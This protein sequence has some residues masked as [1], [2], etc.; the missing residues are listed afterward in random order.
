MSG[1]IKLAALQTELVVK[2]DKFQSELKK[3]SDMGVSEADK[4]SDKMS[5]AVD[6]GIDKMSALGDG[7]TLGLT[8]PILAAGTA[9][10]KFASDTNDQMAVLQ[11]QLGTT[12]EETETLREVALAVYEN[13]F[14]DSLE[15]CIAD[16]GTMRMNLRES[17][18]WTEE[19]TQRTLE[20]IETITSLFD[21]NA[22]EVTRTVQVMQSS[23]LIDNVQE[24]LDIITAGFQNGANYS[25]EL[26][27][28]LREYSPQFVKLGLSADEAMAY[29][30]QGAENGAF[31]LDKVGDAMKEFSIRVVDGS[32]TTKAGFDAINMS[33]DEM[34]EKFGAGGETAK[35]AFKDTLEGLASIEDP[36][37]RNTAGVNLFGTMWED[38]GETVI[39]S[40]A[41][42]EGGLENVEGATERA[43]EQINNTFSS[44]LKSDLRE[45]GDAFLPL[46][47][48][49]LDLAE[50]AMPLLEDAVEEI[51]GVLEDMDTETA[52]NVIQTM[53]M[54]AAIGPAIKT[55]SGGIS[56]FKTFT[57]AISGAAQAV[58]IASGA[59]LT[60]SLG[61]LASAAL[62]L[63]A[64]IAGVSAGVYAFNEHS[65]LMNAT[66]LTSREELSWLQRIFA[67][68]EGVEV[69]SREEL[70]NMG[71]VY[72]EF[73]ENI[74]PEFQSAVEQ[75]TD[76]IHDMILELQEM[77]FDDVLTEDEIASF[78]GK[79][80]QMCQEAIDA[81]EAHKEESTST[82][83]EMF[84]IDDGILD[85][86]ESRVLS[87]LQE[88]YNTQ[89]AEANQLKAE[90]VA[91]QEQAVAEKR[92]LNDQEIADVR[93]KLTRIKELELE[94]LGT[95]QEEQLYARNEFA[96]RVETMTLQEASDLLAEKAALRDQEIIDITASYD[97]QIDLLEQHMAGC[98]AAEAEDYLTQIQKLQEQK[99]EK[100][101]LQKDYY[102]EYV[103]IVRKGNEEAMG[104]VDE[105]TG[106]LLTNADLECREMLEKMQ[107]KYDGLNRITES[108]NYLLL[109]KET[110]KW[111]NVTVLTDEGTGEVIG[112]W[113]VMEE[114]V[115]ATSTEVAEDTEA[116]ASKMGG[117]YEYLST[118]GMQYLESS[119]MVIDGAGQQVGALENVTVAANG[120]RTG[121][122]NLNGTPV[123]VMVNQDGTITALGNITNAINAVPTQK[124]VIFNFVAQGVQS[125]LNSAIQVA[126]ASRHYNGIDNVPYDGYRAILHKNERVLTADENRAYSQP[127]EIDYAKMAA[128]M[129]SALKDM[130]FQVGERDFA[131]LVQSVR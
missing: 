67:D 25:G 46:G 2:T 19:M 1:N 99:E 75:S 13:G 124:E 95:S 82:L 88:N 71:F 26:L 66:V 11:G 76:Q 84:T 69:K 34:A 55:V 21:T 9:F 112:A 104:Y 8:T 86:S 30:I 7:L 59:G 18:D 41:D 10:T 123:Q 74:S 70:E 62:P 116:M 130:T 4:I 106:E 110:N 36:V 77:G 96:A 129:R 27:D 63:T 52:Q 92:G 79:V 122:I 87:Y 35:Q 17:S 73:S 47:E 100:I 53:A 3:A 45:L 5:D 81:I 65:E 89:V 108:G 48:A 125:V 50:D 58:G 102:E 38:L 37:E 28:T 29:L 24:G 80:D 39:L 6:D 119:N 32:D 16:L 121:I 83:E 101:Q 42:V 54:T 126:N 115:G 61:A 117:S 118:A 131:R 111:K 33:V 93:S 68:L 72:K 57:G 94:S 98:S 103:D 51:T 12:A 40:L 97:T 85:A 43:G 20:Q 78:S 31:N 23:G 90:I 128:A 107:E 14:G 56:T 49:V 64:V 44:R 113:Q 120:T 114:G 15:N 105:H 60:G 127:Q 109:D 22:D 91:I